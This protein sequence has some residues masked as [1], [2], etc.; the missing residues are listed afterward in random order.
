MVPS[1]HVYLLVNFPTSRRMGSPGVCPENQCPT[2][3][4]CLS[5]LSCYKDSMCP[6]HNTAL[7]ALGILLG[8]RILESVRSGLTH[9]GPASQ[10]KSQG[11]CLSPSLHHRPLP[12]GSE[13]PQQGA[14]SSNYFLQ[15]CQCPGR[16]SRIQGLGLLSIYPGAP[17]LPPLCT[18]LRTIPGAGLVGTLADTQLAFSAWGGPQLWREGSTALTSSF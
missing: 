16:N 18:T 14:G 13:H 17:A 12:G 9:V 10:A 8:K 5:F 1:A 15:G 7:V 4:G 11:R 3:V 2:H 6:Y